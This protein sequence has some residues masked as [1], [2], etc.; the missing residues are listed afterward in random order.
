[1][2][3]L[4]DASAF[5]KLLIAE[6]GREEVAA[7]WADADAV[8]A[9][10][11][12]YPEARSALARAHRHRRLSAGGLRTAR[13]GLEMRWDQVGVVELHDGVARLAGD[14][15]EMLG[16][17]ARDA[18]HV[19]SALIVGETTLVTFDERLAS[20]AHEAGLAVA[21]VSPGE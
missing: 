15:A 21:G 17:R 9:S 16:L 10:R 20:A 19:A 7:I 8:L 2:R 5:V 1:M 14:V 6:P 13:E 4:I 3:V 18:V 11:I 12:L